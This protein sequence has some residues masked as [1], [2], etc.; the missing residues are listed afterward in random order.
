MSSDRIKKEDNIDS[1]II[2]KKLLSMIPIIFERII[3]KNEQ[4]SKHI[5]TK[6]DC[7]SN[8]TIS[9]KSYLKRLLKYTHIESNTLIH[10]LC[11][12]DQLSLKK[13]YLSNNN[14]HKIFLAAVVISIKLLEDVVYVEKHYA[15][16]GGI[17]LLELAIIENEFLTFINF[18]ACISEKKFLIYYNSLN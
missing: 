6:F 10:A 7:N 11:L 1:E 15:Y 8:V 16:A 14:I 13:V 9:F 18:K 12:I 3:K 2:K 17:S 5:N 4:E